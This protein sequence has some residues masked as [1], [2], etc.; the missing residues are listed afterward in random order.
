[1]R[2]WTTLTW[3]ALPYLYPHRHFNLVNAQGNNPPS[4]SKASKAQPGRPGQANAGSQGAPPQRQMMDRA[5][6]L[7]LLR[8]LN[9]GKV[10]AHFEFEYFTRNAVPRDPHTLGREDKGMFQ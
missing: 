6:E 7:L 10:A 8:P 1:M 2:W 5:T 3:L 4:Q 9:D